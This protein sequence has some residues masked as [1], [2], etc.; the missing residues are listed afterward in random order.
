MEI[1]HASTL[2][3]HAVSQLSHVNYSPRTRK[4]GIHTFYRVDVRLD[5]YSKHKVNMNKLKS[6]LTKIKRIWN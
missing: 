1:P 6:S 5:N 2:P 3:S 4:A